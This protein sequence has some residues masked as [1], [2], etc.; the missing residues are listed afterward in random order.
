MKRWM[1]RIV[2]LGLSLLLCTGAA[3]ESTDD[4]TY[5]MSE[6]LMKQL[7]AGSGF[8]GT[9]TLTAA[10]AEGRESDA[11]STVR[12][13]TL[14]WTYIKVRGLDGAPGEV[15]LKL[16]MDESDYQQGSAELSLE[17][18]AIYM[19]SSLFGEGWYLL[20][21]SVLKSVLQNIGVP[22]TAPA[23]DLMQTESLLPG[24]ASF[25]TNMAAF[26]I[27]WSADGFT[28]AM[29]QYTTKIDFWLEGYRDSVQMTSRD[30][31]VSVMEI[32]YVLP[33]VAVK[34]QLKQLLIDLMNDEALLADLTSLMPKAQADLFLTPSLQPYYFYAVDELPLEE[35]MTI[36]RVVSF[37][38][39][40][41]ELSVTMPLYDSESG[42][43]TMA[44]TRKQGAADM[45]YENTLTITGA[46]SYTELNY[47]TWE[48]M[49]GATVTQGTVRVE[50]AQKDGVKPQIL[51]AAF[52]LSSQA[53]TTK[54]LNG[55]ETLNRTLT[56]TAAPA[57]IADT[58]D[59]SQYAAFS[60]TEL[61]LDMRFKSLAAKN[62]PTDMNL[63]LTLSGE[64]MAQAITLEVSGTTTALWTPEPFDRELATNLAEM[65]AEDLESL[66]SQAVVKGGLLFLP[67][68]NLPLITPET[69]N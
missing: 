15:R 63:T 54:D 34:A 3:A 12:P 13:L 33:P 47:R 52:D 20:S 42:P 30:G 2:S 1:I 44:Y 61:A 38:G 32:E 11:F 56:L 31:G 59:A 67:F 24:T 8:V 10:A 36:H 23:S 5:T 60:K 4:L 19:Q 6:K 51:W 22:G 62:A 39:E 48:T 35:N 55:Y 68:V 37:L 50:G 26:L 66:L 69:A 65:P 43:M 58:E 27:G 29:E 14:D 7:D 57:E 17:N 16:S 64:G 40:T 53:V 46:D 49:T 45:P 21:N 18:G 28:E 41:I 25:F 9:L